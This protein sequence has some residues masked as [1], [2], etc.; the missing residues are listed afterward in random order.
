MPI[1]KRFFRF[2]GNCLGWS[3]RS[4]FHILKKSLRY[5][6]IGLILIIGFII[7][8]GGNILLLVLEAFVGF[9]ILFLKAFGWITVKLLGL[10]K[11]IGEKIGE[12]SD[13]FF[14]GVAEIFREEERELENQLVTIR[15]ELD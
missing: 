2:L 8:L 15:L 1:I 12:F 11:D 3:L 10:T 14:E 7:W 6:A 4:L 9:C 5:I 13:T